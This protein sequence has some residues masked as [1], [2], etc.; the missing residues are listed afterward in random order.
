MTNCRHVQTYAGI[1]YKNICNR[2]D[3][4]SSRSL[5]RSTSVLTAILFAITGV[6]LSQAPGTGAITGTVND[7]A[8]LTV[9]GAKVSVIGDSTDQERTV[10]TA[11]TGTFTVPLLTPGSYTVKVNASG[12]EEKIAVSYTHLTLPTIYSV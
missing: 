1:G 9:S 7:P 4:M 5:R 10:L 6:A 8:G 12:F 11:S 3:R 2:G